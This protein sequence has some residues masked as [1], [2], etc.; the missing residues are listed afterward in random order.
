[1]IESEWKFALF[2]YRDRAELR[3]EEVIENPKERRQ[4][5]ERV[6]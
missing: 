3:R 5:H 1:M 6:D 4:T 2:D